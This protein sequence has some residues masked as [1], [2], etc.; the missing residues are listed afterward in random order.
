MS[1]HFLSSR[2]RRA[3]FTLVELL[4]V[5]AIIGVLVALLLPAVQA[6]REAARRSQCSNNLKQFGIALHNYHD[7]YN[8]FPPR[9]GGTDNSG[10]MCDSSV[11][12]ARVGCNYDRKSAFIFL[13]P[14]IEQVPLAQ[15]IAN[16]FIGPDGTVYPPDGPA[17]W[18]SA[19]RYP[20]WATQLKIVV[21]PSDKL[22]PP[23]PNQHGRSSYVF[24][25][26]DNIGGTVAVGG[27]RV[28]HNHASRLTRGIFG[29]SQRC[30][31]F[32]HITDGSSNT[33]AMSER[34]WGN[35]L[36]Q[37]TATGHDIRTAQ[38]RNV[39]TITTD[40]GSCYANVTG[41]QYI[42]V[43]IKA[44]QGALWSDGQAERVG[45]VTVL[46]PNGP[47]CT[48]DTNNN[49]DSTGGVYTAGS[50]HPNGVMGM[51][52]DGSVRFI[53]QNI[54]TGNLSAPQVSAGPSPYGVWGALG[55]TD[56]NESAANF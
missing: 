11:D 20:P 26:G 22:I 24:S 2:G 55:S 13:L 29:G 50:Y 56:G 49:A 15:T 7:T 44:R 16:Q 28:D 36:G 35:N 39:T 25:L 19:A 10:G 3:G 17:A 12:L 41:N 37:T 5:I 8:V 54:H 18:H 48:N 30:K 40:P 32:N 53:A 6:A 52:A 23:N 14:Y 47:S 9:R 42:G 21:C 43:S 46:P 34:V 27:Q 1:A 38:V 51:F 31:G 4:V 45:F 33:I